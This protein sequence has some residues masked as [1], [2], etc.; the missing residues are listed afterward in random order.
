MFYQ[1][2]TNSLPVSALP[3]SGLIFTVFREAAISLLLKTLLKIKVDGQPSVLEILDTAGTE[4]FASMRDLYIKNGQGFIVVY[5]I[6]SHQTFHDIKQMR[7]QITRVKECVM[8]LVVRSLAALRKTEGER[9]GLIMR[10]RSVSIVVAVF[11]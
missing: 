11:P 2:D 7:E 9:N 6:T 1:T 10:C 3:R 8:V 5:S 4:Q